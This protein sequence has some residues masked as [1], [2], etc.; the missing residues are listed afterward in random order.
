MFN[1]IVD[2]AHRV[3]ICGCASSC[4]AIGVDLLRRCAGRQAEVLAKSD[5]IGEVDKLRSGNGE[6]LPGSVDASSPH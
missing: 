3:Q 1:H 5:P 2:F 6:S 4:R